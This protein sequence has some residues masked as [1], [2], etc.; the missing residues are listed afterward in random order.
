MFS[1]V[2]A[3]GCYDKEQMKIDPKKDVMTKVYW[4]YAQCLGC[5][6]MTNGYKNSW[7]KQDMNK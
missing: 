2:L 1:S 6:H 7:I 5:G 3:A 4:T